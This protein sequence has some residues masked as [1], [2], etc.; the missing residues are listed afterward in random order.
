MP[1]V[2]FE[3]AGGAKDEGCEEE[4]GGQE[5]KGPGMHGQ[6]ISKS[7]E[8]VHTVGRRGVRGGMLWWAGG[9]GGRIIGEVCGRGEGRK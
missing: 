2:V 5:N 4:K 6:R 7:G 8:M 1:G 9:G 3:A